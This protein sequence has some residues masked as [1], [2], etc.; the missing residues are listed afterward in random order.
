MTNK[1]LGYISLAFDGYAA[2]MYNFAVLPEFQNK[3]IGTE[4]LKYIIDYYKN[5]NCESIILDVKESNLKAIHIYEKFNFKTISIR[6]AYYKNG[7]NALI[8]QMN[9]N[10]QEAI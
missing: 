6:K 7:E 9:I 10:S 2:E 1:I 4:I 3:R 5:N 8:M